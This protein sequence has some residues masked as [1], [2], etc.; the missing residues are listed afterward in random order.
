[1]DEDKEHASCRV[2]IK[3]PI[4]N[5]ADPQLWF[6]QLEGQFVL[7][8]I[9][10]DSTKFYHAQSQLDPQYSA[11]VRDIIVSPPATG[12]YEKLK[13][14]LIKRLSASQERKIK[15]LLMHEEL[16]DRKPT[17]FLR[18]LKQL[19]GP[20]VPDDFIRSIWSNRLPPNL[21]TIVAMQASMGLEEVAEL[22]DRINDLVPAAAQVT[23]MQA[24]I[25]LAVEQPAASSFAI[26][27]LTDAVASLTRNMEALS[28]D[29]YRRPRSQSRPSRFQR[30]RS[31]SQSKSRN[32]EY[33][34]YHF[35]FGKRA[36]KCTQ[37]CS[38]GKSLNYQGNP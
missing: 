3:A 32:H 24:N 9:T 5:A 7:A 14:E 33:C 27:A 12:K 30:Q 22:S 2:G 26:T 15:Q 1:M 21:Q 16:G 11:E 35:R 13:Q 18:H 20:S 31:R 23:S 17:Q 6:A 28:T 36:Q 34:W 8:N 10:S 29:F 19:A 4:F 38:F 25:P 37:P